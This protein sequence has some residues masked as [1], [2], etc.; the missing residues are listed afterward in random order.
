MINDSTF[1]AT[2]GKFQ[3]YYENEENEDMIL[4]LFSY[5]RP[6]IFTGELSHNRYNGYFDA[7]KDGE[8]TSHDALVILQRVVGM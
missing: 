4:K 3:V 2:G 8:I 7:D 1:F 5:I 6:P